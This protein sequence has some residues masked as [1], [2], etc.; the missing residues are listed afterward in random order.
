[1]KEM[2]LIVKKIVFNVAGKWLIKFQDWNL[3]CGIFK[4]TLALTWLHCKKNALH[5]SLAINFWNLNASNK[6]QR[7]LNKN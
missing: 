3:Y 5:Q 7:P 6:I 1:M 2:R 4:A